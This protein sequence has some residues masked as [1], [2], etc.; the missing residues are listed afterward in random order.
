MKF[1]YTK[2]NLSANEARQ[3]RILEI[4]PGLTSWFILLGM[5]FLSILKPI[6]AAIFIIAFYF[7]WLL[8]LLYMTIFLVLS[9]LRLNMERKTSWRQRI[10]GID[11]LTLLQKNKNPP[12]ASK[13]IYHLVIYPVVKEKKEVVEPGIKSL[14]QQDFPTERMVVFFALEERADELVKNDISILAEKYQSTFYALK[15]I[16][17]PKDSPGE[18]AVKG[19]NITFAAKKACE[20]FKDKNIPFENI[21]VSCFDADTVVSANYFSALSYYFMITPQRLQASFQPVPVYHN[22]IWEVPGFARVIEAGSSF[23]QLIEATNPEKLV[24]FS[25]HSMSFKALVDV[26]YWP[27]DMISDDSAI[28]WKSFIHF[29]GDYQV[30]PMYIT[31]SMDIAGSKSL[32]ETAKSVYKQKRRW[33]WGVENFPIVMRAFLRSPKIS[34]Y[35]KLRLG[36][37]LF[38]GHVSWASW[39]F[40]LSIIGWLPA[41]FAQQEFVTSV[42][43]YNMPRISHTI[44]RLAAISLI[45]SII[46]SIQLL[47]KRTQKISLGRKFSHALEWLMI[48]VIL[49]IFSSLPALDAQTRLMLG[50]YMGFWVTEKKREKRG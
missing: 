32:R 43:Y 10:R 1:S 13:E 33:A 25:S 27:I 21:I 28:Y 48:P 49:V 41:L 19:A 38:E 26:G 50:R 3:Q 7:F 4:L 31:L 44:F 12:P 29:D 30:V 24:T 15:T 16:V 47:P 34:L 39:G 5:I 23:F 9:Y 2:Q 40:L 22:N 42:T 36:Y 45:T 17:H 35:K 46:L 8:R 37:K 11:E 18:A 6:L 20:F 14:C